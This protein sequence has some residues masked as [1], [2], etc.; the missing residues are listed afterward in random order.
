LATKTDVDQPHRD[1]LRERFGPSARITVMRPGEWSVVYSV[2]TAQ[3]DVVARFGVYDEDFEKDE[4]AAT[5]FSSTTL[6]IPA[7][8]DWGPALGGFYA[9][10][11]RMQG[12]HIDGLDEISVS[13]E[14]LVGELVG[15]EINEY[16]LHPSQF[17]LELYDRRAR[18]LV[19]VVGLRWVARE[20]PHVPR[21][22][23]RLVAGLLQ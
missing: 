20:R 19:P 10:A 14:T 7:I 3:L 15:G 12:E 2:V 11:P 21:K 17:G 4:Y 23:A 1:F 5:H 22:L 6:P 8:I 18:R 9:I 13:A 16:T